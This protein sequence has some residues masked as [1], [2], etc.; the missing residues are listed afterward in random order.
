M[1][2]KAVPVRG[3]GGLR[4]SAFVI[5]QQIS[6][7]RPPGYGLVTGQILKT[8]PRKATIQIT[9]IINATFRMRYAPRIWRAEVI[10]I[11]KPGKPPSKADSYRPMS[12]LPIMSKLLLM[13]LKSV[14]IKKSLIP[15]HQFGFR[16][17]HSTLEQVHRI[18]EAIEQAT[19]EK[20]KV[21]TAV[22]L[23]VSQA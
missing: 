2:S 14:I 15:D 22:F 20:E 19:Q 13:T 4:A 17:L 18:I 8:L 16:N 1:E 10:V 6:P 5:R 11:L 3:R 23:D 7:K 12:L 21:C 9:H